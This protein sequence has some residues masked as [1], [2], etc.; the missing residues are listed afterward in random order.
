ML[1]WLQ[2][3]HYYR[4]P[5]VLA[6]LFLGFSSGLPFLLTLATLHVWL[7]EAGMSKTV[8]G[9]FVLVTIPY[10]LKFLWAPLIDCKPFPYLSRLFGM[11]KGWLMGG[12][13]G[14]I[15]SLIMLGATNPYENLALTAFFA[16]IVAFFSATQD[17]VYEAFRAELLPKELL[18]PGAAASSFGYRLGMWV[19]GAGSLY[20]AS[21]FSWFVVYS[22]MAAS[23]ITGLVAILLCPEPEIKHKVYTSTNIKTFL[24]DSLTVLI[25]RSDLV[26]ILTFICLYK[27]GDTVLNTLSM[28]FLLEIGFSK[29]QIAHIA[30]SFGIM[31]MMIGGFIGGIVLPSFPLY[32]ILMGAS[33]LQCVASLMFMLQAEVGNDIHLLFLTIGIENFAC[34]LGTAAYIVFLSTRCQTPFTATH[35]ALLSSFGSF[36]RILISSGAGMTADFFTWTTFYGLVALLTVPCFLLVFMGK[37]YYH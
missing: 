1:K 28:P 20:L 22:F 35:F 7:S 19:A 21:Y 33:G 8:I 10:S 25:K 18:G 30:K 23:M 27:V 14:V 4:E 5:H 2:N 26:F 11:R 9:L 34:G 6:V 3:A 24:K 15:I 32:R 13:L 36:C 29:L 37:K 17:I 16:F 12:Q 31:A